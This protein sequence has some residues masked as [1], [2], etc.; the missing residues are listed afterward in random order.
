MPD[1]YK[2]F[3]SQLAN[4]QNSGRMDE[5]MQSAV[6]LATEMGVVVCDCYSRWKELSKTRDTTRLLANAINHPNK[7]MHVFFAKCL[8]QTMFFEEVNLENAVDDGLDFKS[9]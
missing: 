2:A 8:Y 6:K 5:F 4:M 7:E 9:D 1:E 3:A